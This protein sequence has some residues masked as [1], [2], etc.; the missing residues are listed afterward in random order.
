MMCS[1][2]WPPP[3]CNSIYCDHPPPYIP[4]FILFLLVLRPS[5]VPSAAGERCLS[6]A[7]ALAL[8]FWTTSVCNWCAFHAEWQL[9]VVLWTP[10]VVWLHW[11]DGW[12]RLRS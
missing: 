12:E 8:S 1:S 9:I 7:T 2:I 11:G 4:S 5:V 10:S 6:R 3:P